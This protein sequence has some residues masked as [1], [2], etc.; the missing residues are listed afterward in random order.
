M[1]DVT[2]VTT[3]V[4]S[5]NISWIVRIIVNDM[6]SY[7]VFYGTDV[8]SLTNSSEVIMGNADLSTI[9]GMFSVNIDDLMPFTT[10]YFI[11]S[12]NNS[13]NT[14]NTA[15]MNFT[16]DETGTVNLLILCSNYSVALIVCTQLLV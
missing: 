10:Y 15:V 4:Y 14:T 16:T 2:N 6:E 5:V 12:A 1:P 8:M 7:T 3:A 9:R 13:V 11:V